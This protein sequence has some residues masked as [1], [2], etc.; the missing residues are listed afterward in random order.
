MAV[1][2]NFDVRCSYCRWPL[3]CWKGEGVLGGGAAGGQSGA[4]KTAQAA[5]GHEGQSTEARAGSSED[6][7]RGTTCRIKQERDV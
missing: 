6:D 2:M 4:A 1:L 3:W 5:E 7:A